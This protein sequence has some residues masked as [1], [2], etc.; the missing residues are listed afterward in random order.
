MRENEDGP[1]E[2]AVKKIH[3]KRRAKDVFYAWPPLKLVCE[4]FAEVLTNDL[5]GSG[6]LTLLEE[7]LMTA[8]RYYEK[9]EP[10]DRL[11]MEEFVRGLLHATP[12]IAKYKVATSIR[13]DRVTWQ[14]FIQ[15]LSE[16][17]NEKIAIGAKPVIVIDPVHDVS[18]ESIRAMIASRIMSLQE[19]H[20][21]CGGD[22]ERI[23]KS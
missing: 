7:S 5:P 19:L 2:Q 20:S 8:F 6:G 15:P 13:R 18:P 1:L 4:R 14:P 3:E 23:C 17:V 12:S 9:V 10:G 22:L 16:W 11:Q 21:I